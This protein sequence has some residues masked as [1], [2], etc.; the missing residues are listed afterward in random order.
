VALIGLIHPIT[1]QQASEQ[2]PGL[3]LLAI[4]F[5]APSWGVTLIA[6]CL[7]H[8]SSFASFT[9]LH[10]VE[11]SIGFFLC[12]TLLLFSSGAYLS[13]RYASAVWIPQPSLRTLSTLWLLAAFPL[14]LFYT[15]P[16]I[17]NL[18]NF[19]YLWTQSG[20]PEFGPKIVPYF[21]KIWKPLAYGAG[22]DGVVL[23]SL[24]TFIAP[25][26]EEIIFSDFW[27][28][29][30]SESLARLRPYSRYRRALPSATR[31]NSDGACIFCRSTF[32]D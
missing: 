4:C 3:L 5:S 22:W 24:A 20:D 10:S 9:A 32:P 28:T 21:Q 23:N 31:S 30:F 1:R 8:W 29:S 17:H 11:Y 14:L 27:R 16:L 2:Q 15:V 6:R 13:I 18:G 26:F 19:A 12:Q 25:F 7:P